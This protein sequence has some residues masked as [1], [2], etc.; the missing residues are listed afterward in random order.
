LISNVH[1]FSFFLSL[2]SSLG[3][4]SLF[5]ILGHERTAGG[6]FLLI[7]L[8]DDGRVAKAK[9]LIKREV[10]RRGGPVLRR[11]GSLFCWANLDAP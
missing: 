5:T 8:D 2:S 9:F 10:T 7:G 4:R 6:E 1:F 11:Y 3:L